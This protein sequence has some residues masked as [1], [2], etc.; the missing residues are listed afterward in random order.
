MIKNA[1]ILSFDK[2]LTMT[3]AARVNGKTI[4]HCHG[5]FNVIHPGHLRFLN[6]AKKQGDI[7]IVSILDHKNIPSFIVEEYFQEGERAEGVAALEMVDAVYILEKPLVEFIT[8]LKP[9][10]YIKGREFENDQEKIADEIKAVEAVK[11]EVVFNS[12]EMDSSLF[13]V[14]RI[15]S[16][17]KR[18]NNRKVDFHKLCNKQEISLS[19]L[20]EDINKFNKLNILVI[21][22]TIVDQFVACDTLGV[23]SEAPVLTIRELESKE[24][25]GGAA[26]IAQHVQ[27]L[28][29]NCTFVSVI[30][31]DHSGQ[32]VVNNLDQAK[33]KKVLIKD[34]SRPTTFKIR[35]MVDNQKLLRVSRLKQHDIHTDIENEIIQYLN[36]IDHIDGIIISDFV[37]GV[38]TENVLQKILDTAKAKKIKVFGDVQCSSQLGNVTKFKNIEL[39]TPTEKEARIGL[40]DQTS[41]LEAL[42]QK[43]IKKTNNQH[44][45]ITL[46]AQGILAYSKTK[47]QKNV[48]SEYFPALE[49]NPVDVAGAGD[50]VM[51]GYALGI[52]SGLNLLEA[53][54]L[55]SCLAGISVSRIGNIPIKPD[56]IKQY[57][58]EI[59]ETNQNYES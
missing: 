17:A 52:C 44:V 30:G 25:V 46:G 27:S 6:F 26:I 28:G 1:K 7:L 32:Y 10:F 4:V 13:K 34:P 35:Y 23:S 12:G 54:A 8:N 24:F 20:Q 56:E 33:I 16:S 15:G 45:V 42:A 31:D 21:G 38:I 55:A 41:G 11:G 43:L 57:I 37:Y 14:N 53:S 50:S 29:A 2:L 5:H 18:K 58:Q 22:D 36:Q 39:I 47:S 9:H 51:A 59:I 3:N 49:E 19:K 48:S 40:S